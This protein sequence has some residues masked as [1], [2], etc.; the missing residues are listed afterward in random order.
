MNL[1][2]RTLIQKSRNLDENSHENFINKLSFLQ[3]ILTPY[4][5]VKINL[6]ELKNDLSKRQFHYKIFLMRFQPFLVFF[7]QSSTDT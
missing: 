2:N 7:Q 4:T 5:S 1:K 6:E 3:T